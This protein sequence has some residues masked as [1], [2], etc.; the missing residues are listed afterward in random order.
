MRLQGRGPTRRQP[1]AQMA[2]RQPAVSPES[3]ALRYCARA[4]STA[5]Q[6]SPP[7]HDQHPVK[8]SASQTSRGQNWRQSTCWTEV[9]PNT[10]NQADQKA[11]HWPVWIGHTISST[12]VSSNS[13]S[14]SL[15]SSTTFTFRPR[16]RVR[17]ISNVHT[18]AGADKWDHLGCV[19]C[20]PHRQ[21][22]RKHHRRHGRCARTP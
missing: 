13:S 20:R 2:S 21:D 3:A 18:S 4:C 10:L 9:Q 7:D 12:C 1:R 11:P 8:L 22:G 17:V 14:S 5:G 16:A 15:S 19:R 6:G